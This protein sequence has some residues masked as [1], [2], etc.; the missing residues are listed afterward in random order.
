MLYYDEETYNENVAINHGTYKY[1]STCEPLLV[2]Y[3]FDDDPVQVWDCTLDKDMPGD[4]NYALNDP[5]ELVTAHSSM[6]DRNVLRYAHGI[7]VPIH[8]WRDTMVQALAH[9]LPGGLDKL[10]GILNVPKEIAKQ[11]TGKQLINLFCKPRPNNV[12][13]KR[14]TRE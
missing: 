10:C 12:K 4:L 1:A 3:A 9:S 7:V 14:A 11:K 8:R 2:T 6:F 5:C 13:I